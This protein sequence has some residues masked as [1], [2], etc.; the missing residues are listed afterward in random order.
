MRKFFIFTTILFSFVACKSSIN[1]ASSS[2]NTNVKTSLLHSIFSGFNK[3]NADS[4]TTQRP[5]INHFNF[6]LKDGFERK[7]GL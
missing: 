3:S 4:C 2:F 1:E 6:F 7:F 5:S